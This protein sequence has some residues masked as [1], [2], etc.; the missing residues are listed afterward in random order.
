MPNSF[1]SIPQALTQRALA[2]NFSLEEKGRREAAL[3]NKN[4]YYGKQES[5]LTILNEDVDPYIINLTKPI[6]KKRTSLLYKKPLLREFTGPSS[7]ISFIE[8]VYQENRIDALLLQT[9]LASELTGSALVHPE[10]TDDKEK[11][12]SGIRLRLFDGSAV[13]VIPEDD[14]QTEAD[15]ISL[16]SLIDRLSK[17]STENN[18]QVERLIKQQIWTKNSVTTYEGALLV[19]TQTNNFNFLPFVNF[20]GEEVYDQ[21]LGHAAATIVRKLNGHI[22]QILTDLGYIIKMQAGT[23]IA[24]EGYQSGEGIVIHP[25]RAFSLPAGAS[26]VPL[27]LD[28]KILEMLE[29]LKYLEEKIF[30]TNSVPKVTI[31]GGEGQSGRELLVRWFPILQVFQE[32]AVRFTNYELE[33]ANMILKVAALPPIEEVNIDYPEADLLPLSTDEET[34]QQDIDL[35][36]KTPIDEIMRRNPEFDEDEAEAELLANK[37]VNDNIFNRN[38]I[39][40]LDENGEQIEEEELDEDGN[41][42]EKEEDPKK[43]EKGKPQEKKNGKESNPTKKKD[44]K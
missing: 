21:Y 31:V 1:D 39:L 11:Y 38:A 20:K 25:G 28:P 18:P 2:N 37:E 42:I 4:Y 10:V 33:L 9:D 6:L 43:D 26:A 24:L 15:S 22:N 40:G 27:D 16:I 44:V 19:N 3:L 7:S 30:E 23:P 13:S 29:V 36:I 35:N 5:E 14:N 17:T 8:K 12:P 32:K 34:L 41:P